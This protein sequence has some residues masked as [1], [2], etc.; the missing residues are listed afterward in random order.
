MKKSLAKTVAD[1][2]MLAYARMDHMHRTAVMIGFLHNS[3]FWL[4]VM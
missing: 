2:N 3:M 4:F 1:V